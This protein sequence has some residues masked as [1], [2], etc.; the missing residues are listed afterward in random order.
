MLTID[1]AEDVWYTLQFAEKLGEQRSLNI[2][3]DLVNSSA[4]HHLRKIVE[5]ETLNRIASR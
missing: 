1:E 2:C 5:S 4:T 3:L